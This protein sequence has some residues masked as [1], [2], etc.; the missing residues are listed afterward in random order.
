[1]FGYPNGNCYNIPN[2]TLSA[3]I[4]NSKCL[5]SNLTGRYVVVFKNTIKYQTPF[6]INEVEVVGSRV[7]N[8]KNIFL[9]PLIKATRNSSDS[10]SL[11]TEQYEQYPV[12][13]FDGFNFNYFGD[14]VSKS[15]CATAYK[16]AKTVFIAVYFKKSYIVQEIIAIQRYDQDFMLNSIAKVEYE[17]NGID[18]PNFNYK[19]RKP[20]YFQCPKLTIGDKVSIYKTGRLHICEIYVLG[21]EGNIKNLHIQI[22]ALFFRFFLSSFFF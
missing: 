15:Y 9:I 11:K 4:I 14:F 16:R 20:N 6:H 1:M 19:Q 8:D 21:Y 7:I 10:K 2:I 13:V 12:K 22:I 5:N 18:C 17:E 3:E